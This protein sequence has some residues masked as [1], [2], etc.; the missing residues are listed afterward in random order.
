[1]KSLFNKYATLQYSLLLLPLA[2]VLTFTGCKKD[3]F[4]QNN[5]TGGQSSADCELEL[6]YEALTMR[7]VVPV[8]NITD[9]LPL[10]EQALAVPRFSKRRVE[11]CFKPNG[12]F[13]ATITM[14]PVEDPVPQN[15]L[16]A[17]NQV[18]PDLQL[19]R[20]EIFNDEAAYYDG[21]GALFDG[22]PESGF[23]MAEAV[24]NELNY[25][26]NFECVT[27]KRGRVKKGGLAN[28]S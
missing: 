7:R 27:K 25:Y 11:A 12:D 5:N 28:K 6:T 3:D 23:N 18:D 8:G 22:T 21:S 17:P 16:G 13:Q 4:A 24:R 20:I 26:K 10:A 1:M 19:Q 15:A 9:T 2:C 14:L